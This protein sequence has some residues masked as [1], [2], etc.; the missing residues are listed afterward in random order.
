[1][2]AFYL[3]RR[4]DRR[5]RPHP[6]PEVEP[7]PPD[8]RP[9]NTGFRSRVFLVLVRNRKFVVLY[10]IPFFG[11]CFFSE[12]VLSGFRLPFRNK[13]RGQSRRVAVRCVPPLTH[14]QRRS[15]K[16]LQAESPSCYILT[17]P[18]WKPRLEYPWQRGKVPPHNAFNSV[19]AN[20]QQSA[21]TRHG[22]KRALTWTP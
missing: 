1:M 12:F 6:V 7:L 14:P 19:P 16:S 21:R 4:R 13:C 11:I 5:K 15:G 10:S 22:R 18:C 20:L 17:I 9:N 3:R 8:L 2:V